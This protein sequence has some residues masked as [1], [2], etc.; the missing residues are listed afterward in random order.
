MTGKEA[1]IR[2]L[3]DAAGFHYKYDAAT[4]QFAHASGILML[5]PE[6]RIS[7]YFYG[8]EYAPRDV[9]L[10]LV[11]A[12]RNQIGNPV[13]RILLFCYHYDPATGKYGAAVMAVLR[14]T[15]AAFVLVCGTFLVI[16]WR[17]DF[18]AGKRLLRKAG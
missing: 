15:G 8:V 16:G 7:R 3:T 10:G 18:R 5:T 6:G 12:S 2:A 14:L 1:S 4:G 11:E 17:R 9:R 13:D